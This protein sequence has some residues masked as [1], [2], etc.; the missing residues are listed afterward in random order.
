MNEKRAENMEQMS[1]S[2]LIWKMSIPS[3]IGIISYNLYNIVDTI[4]ISRGVG[5]YA[6]GGLAITFPLFVFLSAISTT[7]GA[8][9]ASIISRLIGKKN[10]EKASKVA[11]NTFVVFWIIAFMITIIGLIY[12]DQLLYVM[13]VTKNLLPYAKEYTR[14]IL[15]GAITS[16]GFSSLIRAEG[17]SKFAM[18]QW[19][20]PVAVNFILD[21][22]L[23]FTFH[24]GIQ[25]AAIATVLS[26]CISV[27]MFFYYFFFSG[28]SHLKLRPY[29]FLPDGRII[30]EILLIG[31]PSFI[32][33]ASRS[34]MII[35]INN[36]L[37]KYGGDL[38]ISTYGI[39][40]K[41][42][43]FL[44]IPLQGIVQGI[45]PIIGYNYGAGKKDRATKTLNYASV[46]SF[47]YGIGISL[48]LFLLAKFFMYPFTSN[49]EIIEIGSVILKITCLELAF[50]GVY[51]MQATYFQS[52]G[53][54][55][56]SL[57]LYL[58][59]YIL[60]FL[61]TLF[62]LSAAYGLKGVWYSFPL[63]SII[64]LCISSI[65]VSYQFR[66]R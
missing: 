20:I 31:M 16:T 46:I 22:I 3:I 21:P 42:S 48:L 45:Q 61:P 56:I 33:M 51:M 55:K 39:T 52:I 9:A 15:I 8:G 23:I 50:S 40:N 38:S 18:Y 17:S 24:L 28:K 49:E 64:T 65:C 60:C 4:Y 7:M 44:L 62:L 47:S 58:S 43:V 35:V 32:Q 54:A 27:A 30:R 1:I 36:V 19:V 66:K 53:K 25:G 34:L 2:K 11:A 14:I 41:I 5:A 29:H 12:L 10:I 26:Q 63:S 13:G 37:R 6:A 57:A 59:K